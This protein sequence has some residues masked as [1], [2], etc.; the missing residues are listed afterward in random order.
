MV[1]ER[2]VV[3]SN[4]QAVPV[5]V[6]LAVDPGSD[7]SALVSMPV[8]DG[9]G[10]VPPRSPP[11]LPPGGRLLTQV[12]VPARFCRTPDVESGGS[13]ALRILST[14]VLIELPEDVPVTSPRSVIEVDPDDPV[15]TSGIISTAPAQITGELEDGPDLIT[16]SVY[17]T[18]QRRYVIVTRSTEIYGCRLLRTCR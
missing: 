5:Y 3:V 9:L 12:N 4:V 6:R 10:S 11:T 2:Y 15:E 8:T 18:F 14:V 16:S 13:V 7:G 17:G 1:V